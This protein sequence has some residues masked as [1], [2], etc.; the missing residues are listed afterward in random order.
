M[1]EPKPEPCPDLVTEEHDS[2]GPKPHCCLGFKVVDGQ[3]LYFVINKPVAEL[4]KQRLLQVQG[5]AIVEPELKATVVCTTPDPV[6]AHY[7]AILERLNEDLMA[8]VKHA[9]NPN[10]NAMA[11][12]MAIRKPLERVL[13]NV[14]G[15]IPA[16]LAFQAT[17][18]QRVRDGE[19]EGEPE[20]K[21]VD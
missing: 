1:D 3:I 6:V 9:S 14:A 11:K 5:G 7:V 12:T 4:K 15:I 2:K 16:A 10:M 18:E 17:V 13:T 21:K 19:R 8:M 20:P